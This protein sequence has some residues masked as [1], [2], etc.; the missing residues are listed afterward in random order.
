M[1]FSTILA[2][3]DGGEQTTQVL[4]QALRLAEGN[5]KAAL[6]LVSVLDTLPVTAAGMGGSA[7]L[8][9]EV[10]DARARQT[11]REGL[12][13]LARAGRSG[14]AHVVVGNQAEAII[15]EAERLGCDIL[16]LGHRHMSLWRQMFGQSTCADVLEQASCPL[17]IVTERTGEAPQST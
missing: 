5:P 12:A 6:H 4:D 16:V 17:L 1:P 7:D 14:H 2:A 8:T 11:L 10:Q 15:A 13:H 9:L 3:I